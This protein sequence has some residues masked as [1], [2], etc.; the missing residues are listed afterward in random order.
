MDGRLAGER[1]TKMDD[2][3]SAAQWAGMLPG[4]GSVVDLG[5]SALYAA[6]GKW[7][8]AAMTALG[9]VPLIGDAFQFFNKG[10]KATKAGRL[11]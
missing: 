8:D 2:I 9:A 4:I 3:Q 7:G 10:K 1:W 11:M 6:R 5:N